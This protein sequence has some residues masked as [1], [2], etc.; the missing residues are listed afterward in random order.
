MKDVIFNYNHGG[1]VAARTRNS[2][3][4]L[5]IEQDGLHMRA[6]LDGTEEGRRL[7]EEIKGGYID[8]MSFAFAVKE[9]AYN[10]DEHM[11]TILK[12]RKVYD[13]AAVDI[14]AYDTTSISA[15]GSFT[16]EIEKERKHA[17]AAVLRREILQA[18]ITQTI[19]IYGGNRQ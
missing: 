9:S 17:A 4:N 15:R 19:K 2:T 11:R 13:V 12:V 18:E 7:Y 6:R 5:W 16:V 14:P 10:I 3:L 8:R 1:K